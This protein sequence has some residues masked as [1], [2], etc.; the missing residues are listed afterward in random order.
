MK[1]KNSNV[2]KSAA[3]LTNMAFSAL[4]LGACLLGKSTR[5]IS[6]ARNAMYLAKNI[7][8]L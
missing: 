3:N 1:N 8:K 4:Y 5:P 2:V 6:I 7:K